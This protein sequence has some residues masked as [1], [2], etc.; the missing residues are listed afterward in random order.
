[1]DRFVSE[2]LNQLHERQAKAYNDTRPPRPK[3]KE[4]DRV[5]ILRPRREKTHSRWIGPCV[6]QER[7]ADSS[8]VV[9]YATD[10]EKAVHISQMKPVV[11]DVFA[12]SEIGDFYFQQTASDQE[13][14]DDD[15]PQ[16]PPESPE[17]TARATSPS[18][19]PSPPGAVAVEC[20]SSGDLEDPSYRPPAQ[21]STSESD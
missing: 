20:D 5:W 15:E 17:S 19:G 14:G 2:H 21:P 13:L 6:V 7:T 12:G 3:F 4:G 10:N 16:P 1:M 18:S 8:Y 9:K 11:D